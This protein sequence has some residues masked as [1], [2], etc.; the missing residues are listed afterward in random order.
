LTLSLPG[1]AQGAGLTNSLAVTFQNTAE[2][3]DW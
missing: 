3:H 1:F 2:L